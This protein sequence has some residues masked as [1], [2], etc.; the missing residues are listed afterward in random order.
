MT[1]ADK[2]VWAM[3]ANAMLMAFARILHKWL[4]G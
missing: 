3:V 4:R 2:I 1:D